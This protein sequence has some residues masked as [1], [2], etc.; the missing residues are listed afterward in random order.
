MEKLD[1]DALLLSLAAQ[2]RAEGSWCGETH[3]QKCAF[4][5]QSLFEPELALPFVMYK[6]GPFSFELREEL[7]EMRA[8]DA[9]ALIPQPAPYGPTYE[10]TEVG[11]RLINSR[12]ALVGK[13]DKG[14]SLVAV[15]L[16]PKGVSDLERLATALYIRSSNEIEE[17]NWVDAFVTL[18]PHISLTEAEWAFKEVDEFVAESHGL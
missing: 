2:M 15:R 6:H 11:K 5:F 13:H 16:S 18:K 9:L 10:V 8:D 14:L 12:R 17:K 7:T 1:R 3:V 4:F